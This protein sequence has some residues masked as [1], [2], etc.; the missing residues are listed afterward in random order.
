MGVGTDRYPGRPIRVQTSFGAVE[1][2]LACSPTVRTLDC[3]HVAGGDFL[4]ITDPLGAFEEW[5]FDDGPLAIRKSAIL[6][7]TEHPDYA[8]SVAFHVDPG[9]FSRAPVVLRLGAFVVRGFVHVPAG[10][11]PL[12]RFHQD[13]P[14]FVAVTSAAVIGPEAELA[15]RFIA[16]NRLHVSAA[17]AMVASRRV[18]TT[19]PALAR[20]GS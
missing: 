18:E 11:T 3:L 12:A 15:A 2:L 14:P 4:T 16:V 7:V 1:G 19:E 20:S 17:Q 10:A 8:A 5:P 6:F 13:G 9:R